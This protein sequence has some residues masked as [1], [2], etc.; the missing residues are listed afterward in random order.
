MNFKKKICGKNKVAQN[1]FCALN[2]FS[3]CTIAMPDFFPEITTPYKKNS[4]GR[5]AF[6]VKFGKNEND[7]LEFKKAKKRLLL[8]S[9]LK[10]H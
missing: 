7:F 10:T 2:A 4:F 1:L 8:S 9:C 5:E 3:R 6:S